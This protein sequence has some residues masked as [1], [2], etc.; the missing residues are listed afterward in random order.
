MRFIDWSGIAAL[1]M[2]TLQL[3]WLVSDLLTQQ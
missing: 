2:L 3:S 1:S